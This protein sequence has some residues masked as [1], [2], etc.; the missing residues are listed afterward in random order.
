M[1]IFIG[2][3]VIVVIAFVVYRAWDNKRFSE[4]YAKEKQFLE[5]IGAE[6][7]NC[8]VV[9]QEYHSHKENGYCGYFEDYVKERKKGKSEVESLA[10]VRKMYKDDRCVFYDGP[11]SAYK[12]RKS[13]FK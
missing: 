7:E 12:Q 10:F 13:Q 8:D 11:K 5:T 4:A 9:V 6:C 3:I 2:L 1:E